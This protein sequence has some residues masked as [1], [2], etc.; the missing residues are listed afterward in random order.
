MP[1]GQMKRVRSDLFYEHR[2]SLKCYFYDE[3]KLFSATELSLGQIVLHTTW[4]KNKKFVPT[5]EH[6]DVIGKD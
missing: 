2:T 4:T 3:L 6:V 5:L 1:E